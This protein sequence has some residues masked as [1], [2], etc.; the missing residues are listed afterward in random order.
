[1]IAPWFIKKFSLFCLQRLTQISRF[2]TFLTSNLLNSLHINIYIYIFYII[3]HFLKRHFFKIV[4][5]SC[6]VALKVSNLKAAAVVL[7]NWD[8]LYKTHC[9]CLVYAKIIQLQSSIV[10][11]YYSLK[12]YGL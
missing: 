1:M 2:V 6:V 10:V 7:T 9:N 5:F 8:R 3:G 12:T 11:Q 4:F